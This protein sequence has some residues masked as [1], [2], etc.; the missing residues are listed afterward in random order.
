MPPEAVQNGA[1]PG[2]PSFKDL[3]RVTW[4]ALPNFPR[5][6]GPTI[7]PFGRRFFNNS[8]STILKLN[9]GSMGNARSIA[10]AKADAEAEAI[11]TSFAH[12][13]L[14]SCVPRL[15]S[16]VSIT[17]PP[18]FTGTIYTRV[19]GIHLPFDVL[20][21]LQ[22]EQYEILLENLCATLVELRKRQFNYYGR[23]GERPYLTDTQLA[24]VPQ[25]VCMTRGEWNSARIR[26]L[27][28]PPETSHFN[29]S[30][31]PVLEHVQHTAGSALP[32]V[33]VPV[34]THGD[35]SWRNI[36]FDPVT[37][38]V[39]GII[40]WG[41][42][43]IAPAYM[44]YVHARLSGR[45]EPWWR[46]IILEVLRRVLLREC[47]L[48]AAARGD[49]YWRPYLGTREQA[50]AYLFST[51]LAAWKALVDVERPVQGFAEAHYWTY[52]P[53]RPYPEDVREVERS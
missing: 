35:L 8:Q 12:T 14:G 2:P 46:P 7:P 31:L 3:P 23:P 15:V 29:P 10:K 53:P 6:T 9:P 19:P 51:S 20:D 47:E 18:T 4:P 11:M 25:A 32:T 37:L 43:N 26:A 45:H 34:L 52:D 49:A 40:D 39:T 24:K 38:K 1:H 28:N 22:P 16:V 48:E 41:M 30:Q 27:R 36:L 33:E 44:E 42:G 17:G 5:L 13:V 50:A 21:N